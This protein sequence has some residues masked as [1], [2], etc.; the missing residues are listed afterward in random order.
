MHEK[1]PISEGERDDY[2][3]LLFLIC[4]I[5]G[6]QRSDVLTNMSLGN[7]KTAETRPDEGASVSVDRVDGDQGAGI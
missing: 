5:N 7:V 1:L 4:T 6:A 3:S 2:R